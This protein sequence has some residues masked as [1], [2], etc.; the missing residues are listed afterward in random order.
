M[1]RRAIIIGGSLAGLFAG[2][3]LRRTGWDVTIHE[4]NGVDL[5]ARGA[6]IVTHD[7]L[8][9]ILALAVGRR[10]DFGVK[11]TG[12]TV[13]DVDGSVVCENQNEHIVASW[14]QLWKRLRVA[15]DDIYAHDSALQSFRQHAA[16]VEVTFANGVFERCDLLVAA[17]GIQSTIRRS[18]MS[19]IS[20][21]YAGY[22]AW[23]GLVDKSDL[24][25]ATVMQLFNRFG[26]C[27]PPSE[28]MLGYPVE[29]GAGGQLR[30]N[31]VWY[32]PAHPE[33]DLPRLLAGKDGTQYSGGIPPDQIRA[34]VIAEMQDSATRLLAPAF[35]EVVHKTRQ[36]LLQP[37]VD[38]E[39]P[40]LHFDRVVLLG[41]AAFVARPH[42][43]MGVTK[44]AEDALALATCLQTGPSLEDGL[45]AF[46]SERVAA[47]QRIIRRARHLGAY[48]QAQRLSE[49]E[50][51][52]ANA[53]R[54]P[55]AVMNET[56][57]TAG[58][59]DW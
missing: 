26:F 16:F 51:H 48:M 31:Y 44:A 37:I 20:P 7:S 9:D 49:E 6:G 47:S 54:S 1:T 28:Q 18:L 46:S 55:L 33:G 5:G 56:A 11:L 35:A 19:K 45:R 21:R 3:L 40:S 57:T 38:L 27:L 4:R 17:D 22:I 2:L 58:M 29:G 50:R 39:M 32:R 30:Y 24:S 25:P 15:A 36:P 23:R 41:D 59:A 10:D 13:I 8:H 34:E 12:R 14:D 53:H 52:H 43:G 42:V